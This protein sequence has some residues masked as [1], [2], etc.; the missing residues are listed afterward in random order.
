MRYIFTLLF[1]I[2]CPIAAATTYYV[3][4]VG[5][6]AATGMAEASAWQTISRVNSFF[7]SMKPGDKVLF[8][9]GDTFYGTLIVSASGISGN[10]IV[11]GSYGSG[12]NPVIT[13]LTTL[14]GWTNE[15]N[16]IYSKTVTCQSFPNLVTFNGSPIAEGRWPNEGSMIFESHSGT[17]SITDIQLTDSP[18][19][20]NAELVIRSSDYSLDRIKITNHSNST[21][22]YTTGSISK[23]PKNGYGYWIQNDIETLDRTGEWYYDGSKLYVYFGTN[24]PDSYDV[25]IA[26]LDKL[27]TIRAARYITL[28]NVTF[29]GCNDANVTYEDYD[30]H[31]III[32]NCRIA[33]SGNIGIRFADPVYAGNHLTISNCVVENCLSAGIN[34]SGVFTYNTLTGNTIRN[35][36]YIEG[37]GSNYCGITVF[38]DN[39]V[40]EYNTIDNTGYNGLYPFCSNLTVKNNIISNFC[41]VLDDGGGIYMGDW[42]DKQ[43]KIIT[44]NI[45]YN[46]KGAPN[47]GGTASPRLVRGIYIDTSSGSTGTKGIEVTNNTIFNCAYDGLYITDGNNNVKV[48]NNNIYNNA[49]QFQLRDD[50]SSFSEKGISVHNNVFFSRNANQICYRFQTIS[51]NNFSYFGTSDNNFITR[52]FDDDDVFYTYNPSTGAKLRTL[53]V[54]QSLTGQDLNS[55][56]ATITI[57]DTADIDFYYNPTKSTKVISLVQPM[58]DAKGTS[59]LN[60]VTLE[61]FASVILMV[62]PNPP[63]PVVPVYVSSVINNLTPTKVEITYTVTLDANS[64]PLPSDFIVKVNGAART[65]TSV[66]ISGTKVIITLASPVIFGDMV[67]ISYTQNPGKPLQTPT[68]GLA[69]NLTDVPVNNNIVDPSIANEAPKVVINYEETVSS[70]FVYELDASGTTDANNDDLTFTWTTPLNIP[71]SGVTG[72][73]IRYLTPVVSSPQS[74]TFGLTVSDGKAESTS[75][76]TV[77]NLPY[78]PALGPGN[79][80]II[81]ASNYYQSDYPGNV[82][83]GLLN[84]KWSVNGDNQWITISLAEP[85]KINHVQIALLPGQKYESYFDLFASRD[86]VLWEPVLQNGVSCGFSGNPQNYVLPAD[87]TDND[88]Y[89]LKLL[90]HGNALDTWNNYSEIRLFGSPGS[91]FKGSDEIKNIAIYPNPA[92]DIINLLVLEPTAELQTLRIFDMT[93]K[94]RFETNIDPGTYNVQIPLTLSPGAYIVQVLLGKLIRFAQT[95]VIAR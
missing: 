71:V 86:N 73:K 28:D 42:T 93:G 11:I 10:P 94:I 19:W 12:A 33:N 49:V 15:G 8:R 26:T 37:M 24:N 67:T 63:V 59:Y 47:G 16:G 82:D 87:K 79:V 58:L 36:G 85:L 78:K 89:F 50:N 43:N 83:D 32:Q 17:T 70:G 20:T 61:P 45:I 27:I 48:E 95:L 1:F 41:T 68:L 55:K 84:T 54:W 72:S 34:I 39:T 29:S 56:K 6:D 91:T 38:G 14:T 46:G 66:T 7:P 90:G 53:S 2:L 74:L 3:S 4:S 35:A 40:L 77:N 5:S 23:E 60:S 9:K 88:Y 81:E 92:R 52:P 22:T 57:K 18:N 44:G 13:G 65:I 62:D 21:I 25:R 75:S 30:V 31:D 80:R 69:A 64:V 76:L 51:N